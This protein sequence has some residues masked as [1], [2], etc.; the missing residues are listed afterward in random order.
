LL[1]TTSPPSF[2]RGAGKRERPR[3]AVEIDAVETACS[4]QNCLCFVRRV[5]PEKKSVPVATWGGEPPQFAEVCHEFVSAPAG[6]CVGRRDGCAGNPKK[7]ARGKKPW[8]P[9]GK[10]QGETSHGCDQ[11]TERIR[12]VFH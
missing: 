9:L 11:G 8:A 12:G 4:G 6:P 10:H 3:A 2:D 7:R 1:L 5:I